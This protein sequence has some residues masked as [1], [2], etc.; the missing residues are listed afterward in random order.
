MP[1]VPDYTAPSGKTIGSTGLTADVNAVTQQVEALTD[2]ANN[3]AALADD[4]VSE[5]MLTPAVR[6]KLN[7]T[8]VELSIDFPLQGAQSRDIR[9]GQQRLV[10]TVSLASN[11]S[12][13]SNL[14]FKKNGAVV[15]LPVA[16]VLAD[17]L[18]VSGS[19]PAG[20]GVVVLTVS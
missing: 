19:M 7:Q 11:T 4:S 5:A 3:Q 13:M 12:G 18:T 1:N 14:T 17:V 2:W 16:V 6:A 9:I 8:L 15:A 10:G 20:G